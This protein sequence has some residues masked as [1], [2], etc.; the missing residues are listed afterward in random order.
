M[1]TETKIRRTKRYGTLRAAKRN[2]M[3]IYADDVR[4][5]SRNLRAAFGYGDGLDVASNGRTM[6]ASNPDYI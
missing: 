4:D 2:G 1:K 6:P 3:R 5:A